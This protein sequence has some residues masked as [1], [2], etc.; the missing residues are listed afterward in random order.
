MEGKGLAGID[1]E[2]K[3]DKRQIRWN[4]GVSA[5]QVRRRIVAGLV[6]GSKTKSKATQH[7]TGFFKRLRA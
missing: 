7:N 3:K 2:G 4:A 5:P 6:S 1:D